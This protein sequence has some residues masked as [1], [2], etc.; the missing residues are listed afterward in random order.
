MDKADLNKIKKLLS[1]MTAYRI[2]KDTGIGE[3][4]ISRW[5]TGKTALTKMSLG[6][7]IALTNYYDEINKKIK[8]EE[9]TMKIITTTQE[10]INKI[11]SSDSGLPIVVLITEAL[12]EVEKEGKVVKFR[13]REFDDKAKKHH[14]K[15]MKTISEGGDYNMTTQEELDN[16]GREFT[17]LDLTK[18]EI[19][20]LNDF[21]NEIIN[22]FKK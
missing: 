22:H 16:F 7:A 11:E 1:Q 4:T 5:V 19:A 13:L 6:H 15:I 9:F 14:L 21:Y 2:S 18:D 8:S 17:L 20:E 3:T 12:A 10:I